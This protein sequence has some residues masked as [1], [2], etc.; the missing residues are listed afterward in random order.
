MWRSEGVWKWR[1]EVV[2]KWRKEGVWKIRGR[3]SQGARERDTSK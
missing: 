1:R 2:W 3:K